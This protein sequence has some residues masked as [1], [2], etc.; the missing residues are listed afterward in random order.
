MF[1]FL[2]TFDTI[3]FS[4]W[5][6][7]SFR[8]S[9]VQLCP[10]GLCTANGIYSIPTSSSI[11]KKEFICSH[12]VKVHGYWH[13]AWLDP[14]AQRRSSGLSFSLHLLLLFFVLDSFSGKDLH[15]WWQVDLQQLRF[16]FSQLSDISGKRASLSQSFQRKSWNWLQLEWLLLV[17]IC[18][19]STVAG[20][21]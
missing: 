9:L 7:A 18:K 11:Y 17:P 12:E 15:T 13:Q 10:S 20:E 21:T 2:G 19:P 6:H 8:I 5:A 3:F 1:L 16:Y 14:C 4:I